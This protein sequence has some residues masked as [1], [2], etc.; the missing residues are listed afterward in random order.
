MDDLVNDG[1]HSFFFI[2][3]SDIEYEIIFFISSMSMSHL[4]FVLQISLIDGFP[5]DQPRKLESILSVFIQYIYIEI[6]QE[7]KRYIYKQIS[8][9]GYTEKFTELI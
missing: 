1:T 9:S 3:D 2:I 4:V 8:T 7:D 5:G 6:E